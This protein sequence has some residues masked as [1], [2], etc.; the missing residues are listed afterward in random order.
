[1]HAAR[2]HVGN[3]KRHDLAE[4]GVLGDRPLSRRGFT[5]DDRVD[6]LVLR[7]D[8]LVDERVGDAGHL[9]D[10]PHR[11]RIRIVPGEERLGRV[12]DALGGPLA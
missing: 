5:H 10:L 6:D 1:V 4:V 12:E 7:A 11:D 9:G 3:E 8:V 2:H